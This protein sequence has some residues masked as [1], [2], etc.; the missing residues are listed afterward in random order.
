MTTP[1]SA[2][3]LAD[4]F[5][6]PDP[7]TIGLEE[8][9]MLLDPES[10]ELAP[11]ASE[12]LGRLEGDPRFKL[13]LPAAHLEIVTPPQPDVAS[14]VAALAEGRERLAAAS[15]G[16]A[17][18]AGAGV[19]PVSPAEGPLNEGERYDRIRAEY[20]R[21]AERQL[22]C[23]LQ[24][25][26]AVGGADRTLAVYNALRGYMPELAALAA[27]APF[28]EGRDTGLASIRPKISETLPRQG[29]PPPI[30]S[31]QAFAAELDWG[32]VSGALPEPG[33]WWWELRPH[34]AF[35]TL[36]LRVPDTQTTLAEAE[37]VAAFA[38]ALVR[39]LAERHEAGEHLDAPATW[40]IEQ[41]RWAASRYGVEGEMADL[42]TGE[43]APT[44]ERLLALVEEVGVEEA[45]PLAQR[46]GAMRQREAAAELGA[47]GLPGWLADRFRDGG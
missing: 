30:E 17:R 37:A 8:E 36:E 28:L 6:A 26:V 12:V 18:P 4:A 7:L 34:P 25:H 32:A 33:F 15:E 11:V 3:A 45:R 27:N 10:L 19:H 23:A 16:L 9:L 20:G 42:G 47:H 40:R 14:A 44:R 46:N 43:R 2:A 31:W 39:R 29:V 1:I 21:V 38:H 24:V 5:D 22:V 35:G 13:E 41:N